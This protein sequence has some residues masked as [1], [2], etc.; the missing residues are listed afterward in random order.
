MSLNEYL[1]PIHIGGTHIPCNLFLAP[2]AGFTDQAFRAVCIE[3]G[4]CF[5]YTEM[6]SAEGLIRNNTKTT[7]LLRRAPGE[8]SYGI[9]L[10]TANPESAEAAAE[11]C[12]DYKPALIDLNCGCPV[13]KVVKN[14]AGAALLD[15]PEQLAAVV[16]GLLR[17]AGDIPVSVKI[18]TGW[19][20]NSMNYLETGAAAVDGG[21]S[22]LCLHPRTRAQGYAGTAAWEHIARLKEAVP[23]PVLGSGDLFSPK[24]AA[25]LFAATGCDGLIFA[26][27]AIGNPFLFRQTKEFFMTGDVPPPP[28]AAERMETAW[29]QYTYLREQKGEKTAAKEIK[30]HFAAYTKGLPHSGELRNK[31]MHAETTQMFEKIIKKYL[32]ETIILM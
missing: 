30:K 10:F 9:Q 22:A 21:A 5:T 27:G 24:D 1:H 31:L 2:L 28:G 16:R 23:V 26:R 20:D 15:N 17:G 11:R 14:G 12:R 8:N 29:H 13:P 32:E 6:V 18:R 19:D 25:E 4:A 3:N 7:D